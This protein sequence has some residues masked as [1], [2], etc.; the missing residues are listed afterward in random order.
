MEEA[1]EIPVSHTYYDTGEEQD[2]TP[3]IRGINVNG[4]DVLHGGAHRLR[5][6]ERHPR[7]GDRPGHQGH[8]CKRRRI[9]TRLRFGEERARLSAENGRQRDPSGNHGRF[10]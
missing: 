4:G 2:D 5:P 10:L 1:P 9:Q 8:Q 6:K 3:G 7:G